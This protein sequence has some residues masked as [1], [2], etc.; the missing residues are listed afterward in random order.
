MKYKIVLVILFS[1]FS[2]H[3]ELILRR[4]YFYDL[5]AYHLMDF[6]LEDASHNPDFFS[7]TLSYQSPDNQPKEISV[8]FLM[9]ATLPAYNMKNITLFYIKTNPFPF[10][11]RININS[12]EMDRNLEYISYQQSGEAIGFEGVE[13]EKYISDAQFKTL[14][15]DV[16]ASGEIPL[17]NYLFQ[18]NV[19]ENNQLIASDEKEIIISANQYLNLLEPGGTLSESTEI[20]TT[21]PVFHW[22]TEPVRYNPSYCA[23]CGIYIRVATFDENEDN[24]VQEALASRANI[25]FPDDGG[26]YK[27]PDQF[28]P[29]RGVYETVNRFLYP[30]DKA[31]PLAHGSQYVWQ[32]KKIFPSTAGYEEIISPIYYFRIND[33]AKISSKAAREIHDLL[34]EFI[35]SNA[36]PPEIAGL[37]RDYNLTGEISLGNQ[38]LSPAQLQDILNKLKS[39]EYKLKSINV[40]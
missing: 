13:T 7:Y 26:F 40:K 20:F 24:S 12:Q 21:L 8:E 9:R 34:S 14:R 29:D 38:Q 6:D 33:T 15:K 2:V 35:Q 10:L 22:D 4:N 19:Y 18:L 37:L 31:K 36:L 28:N 27:I 23:K 3:G 11:G 16:M 30:L 25:P 32:V 5:Q 39:G 17:G 1:F